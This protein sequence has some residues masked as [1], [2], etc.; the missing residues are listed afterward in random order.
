MQYS[1]LIECFDPLVEDFT[2]KNK[3][4]A[5]INNSKKSIP[6]KIYPTPIPS[7][8]KPSSPKPSTSKP[9]SPKSSSPKPPVKPK[10][11]P[12]P[13]KVKIPKP[14]ANK[15]SKY[16]APVE[17]PSGISS[18]NW[19]PWWRKNRWYYGSRDYYYDLGY[20]LWWLDYYY[21]EWDYDYYPDAIYT[22]PP[23]TII[24]QTAEPQSQQIQP[25]NQ[26]TQQAYYETPSISQTMLIGMIMMFGFFALIIL[27]LFMMK[28]N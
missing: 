8:P 22:E 24:T 11:S 18:N 21:P 28:K 16:N 15:P 19:E 23:T 10:P 7:T 9:V 4:K 13:P 3:G 2:V 27:F 20:P 6:K 17:L 25:Q 5:S 1:N 26:Q 14:P 12:K